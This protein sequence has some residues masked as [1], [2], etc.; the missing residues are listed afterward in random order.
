M[1]KVP[2]YISFDCDHGSDLKILLVGQSQNPDSP[3][4]I[5]DYSIKD[6]S[7]DWKAAAR[8]LCRKG[9]GTDVRAG[10]IRAG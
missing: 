1:A 8:S 7:P 4:D 2:I 10:R 5:A 3:F 9:C 6:A